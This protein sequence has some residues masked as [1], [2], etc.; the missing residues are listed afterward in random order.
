[1][2][3]TDK[4]E[5][6]DQ[7]NIAKNKWIKSRAIKESGLI[8]DANAFKSTFEVATGKEFIEGA[9]ITV[10]DMKLFNAEIVKLEKDL[11]SAGSLSVK[12]LRYF[13]P[14][15]AKMRSHPVT[16]EFYYDIV[17]GNE[18]RANISG[19]MLGNYNNMVKSIKEAMVGLD[20]KA[21]IKEL[22][23][24]EKNYV[25]SVKNQDQVGVQRDIMHLMTFLRNEGTVFEDFRN[26]VEMG[27]KKGNAYL[28]K[29]YENQGK[30]GYINSINNA[31]SEWSSIQTRA[32]GHLK[33][34]IKNLS[35][36]ID[37]KYGKASNT[38]RRLKEE[39]AKVA[40]NLDNAE[41]GYIPHYVLDIFG[42]SVE[43]PEMVSTAKNPVELDKIMGDYLSRVEE[44]NTNLINRLKAKSDKDVEY[45]SRNPMMYAHKYIEQ[46]GGFNNNAYVSHKYTKGLKKLSEAILRDPTSDVAQAAQTYVDLLNSMH[47]KATHRNLME[48]ESDKRNIVRILTSLQFVSK[49]GFS[50]RGAVRN[51]TQRLLNV[52]YWDWKTRRTAF[53]RYREDVDYKNGLDDQLAKKG[54]LFGDIATVTDGA[55][56]NNDLIAA[57][58]NIDNG[59]I[60]FKEQNQVLEWLANKTGKVAEYSSTFTKWAENWNRQSTFKIAYNQRLAQLERSTKY[61]NRGEDP[62]ALKA[63]QEVAGTYAS[64]I[65]NLLHFDYSKMGKSDVLSS[66]AGAVLGQFQH[67]AISFA[68]LQYQMVKD[69]KRAFK[70]EGIKAMAGPEIAR[71]YRMAMVYGLTELA[72]AVMNI[73]FTSYINNDTWSRFAELLRFLGGDK[74]AFYGK[75]IVGA[76]GIVPASDAIEIHNLGAAAGYWNMIADPDSTA[77]YLAGMREYKKIDD[78]EFLKEVAGMTSIELDRILRRSVGPF[79]G[80]LLGMDQWYPNKS[81]GLGG[82]VRAE[83]GAYPGKT[84]VAGMKTRDMQKAFQKSIGKEPTQNFSE[85]SQQ[86]RARAALASLDRLQT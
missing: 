70:A 35:E 77:G 16:R 78:T 7:A 14:G 17:K 8:D 52:M 22:N 10:R 6:W 26:R 23:Q 44:I 59:I 81:I 15:F 25:K 50:T 19:E 79:L 74:D 4:S 65:T 64:K 58:V 61:A 75:G 33:Q 20:S 67:Y 72:S 68:D 40:D 62:G 38:A 63:M 32:Q 73:D 1:M 9:D 85:M 66:D 11:K 37:L 12:F 82:L 31:A 86:E 28:L 29:K 47:D 80:P 46:V 51:S 36:T 42:Q 18:M 43:L 34:A 21:V 48:G 69:T 71:F 41:G 27:D 56:T 55:V 54:L 2:A 53:K 3:C 60:T 84:A 83:F 76:V 49:L 45:F 13:M 39:Y 5:L 24:L 30:Q 57:G